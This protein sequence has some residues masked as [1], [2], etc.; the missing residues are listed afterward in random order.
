[1]NGRMATRIANPMNP[2]MILP[3]IAVVYAVVFVCIH[4]FTFCAA[5]LD[6]SRPAIA[7]LNRLVSSRDR[8]A[9]SQQ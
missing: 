2:H 8:D 9:E 7:G 3:S 1:M 4:I 6:R 5:V